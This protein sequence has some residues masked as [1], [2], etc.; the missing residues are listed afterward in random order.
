MLWHFTNGSSEA[1]NSATKRLCGILLFVSATS[2]SVSAADLSSA[3]PDRDLRPWQTKYAQTTEQLLQALMGRM[4]GQAPALDDDE[5][6]KLASVKLR[7]PLPGEQVGDEASYRGDPLMFYSRLDPPEVVLPVLSLKFFADLCLA[8]VWLERNGFEKASP[9]IYMKL[10][11][12]NRPARFPGHH[13]PAVLTAL[14]IPIDARRDSETEQNYYVAFNYLRAF[15]LLHELGHIY[16]RHSPT[17]TD[18]QSQEIEADLFALRALAR[19][20]AAPLGP[21][22]YFIAAANL[23]LNRADFSSEANWKRY[24][25]GLSH[26]ANEQRLRNASKYVRSNLNAFAGADA[27]V[28]TIN[29]FKE[30]ADILDSLARLASDDKFPMVPPKGAMVDLSPLALRKKK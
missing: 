21:A 12:Y 11:K 9:T 26:P 23:Q 19:I 14:G 22:L 16:H 10:V 5:R 18:R 4:I 8:Y 2:R 29:T 13:Y 3:Y 1:M 15:L 17:A 24:A 30:F 25:Q 28:E 20:Q 6:R 7:F 27:S